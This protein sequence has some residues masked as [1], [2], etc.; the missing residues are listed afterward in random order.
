MRSCLGFFLDTFI[1]GGRNKMKKATMK[2]LRKAIEMSIAL[3]QKLLKNY[4]N[5]PCKLSDSLRGEIV[6]FSEVEA[7]I[8]DKACFRKVMQILELSEVSEGLPL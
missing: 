1:F 2:E 4:E 3:N 5:H 6:A 8:D 7:W